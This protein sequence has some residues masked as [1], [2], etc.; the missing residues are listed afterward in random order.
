MFALLVA[1][2]MRNSQYGD[3]GFVLLM[4]LPAPSRFEIIILTING[5]CLQT[6]TYM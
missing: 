2:C 1:Q 3:G 5:M 6:V 4:I